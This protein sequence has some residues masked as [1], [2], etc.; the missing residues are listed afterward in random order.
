MN[1][2]RIAQESHGWYWLCDVIFSDGYYDSPEAAATAAKLDPFIVRPFQL[3]YR[4]RDAQG[5]L[6]SI[7]GEIER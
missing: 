1:I 2:V 6:V 4:L 3:W 7:P 5:Q